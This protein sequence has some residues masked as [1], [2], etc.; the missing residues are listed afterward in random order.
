MILFQH[1]HKAGGSSIVAMLKRADL[2]FHT[3]NLNGNPWT[4]GKERL[5]PFWAF[6]G[7]ELTDWLADIEARGV[8]VICSEWAFFG[9][10]TRGVW[11]ALTLVTCLRD[12]ME[13]MISG[14]CSSGGD[15]RWKGIERWYDQ[16][17]LRRKLAP[18]EKMVV[19]HN[20]RNHYVRLLSGRS[21]TIEGE[22][23]E[24]DLEAA[25]ETLAMFDSV[26]ILELAPS[27]RL[28]ERY[29]VTGPPIHRNKRSPKRRAQISDAFRRRFIEENQ[30]DYALYRE[31]RTISYAQR[32][33]RS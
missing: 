26:L 4:E 11:S 6:G 22:L 24:K 30:L 5:I 20:H 14:Y 10:A 12:P 9:L 31:A 27:F 2:C 33:S 21:D 19:T 18:G 1:F 3:S 29:G 16:A 23:I 28:L 15:D 32:R 13:R 17:T 8:E 25:Q 7:A